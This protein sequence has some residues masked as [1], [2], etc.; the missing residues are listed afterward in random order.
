MQDMDVSVCD[1][2]HMFIETFM[3]F[4]CIDSLSCF[5]SPLWW[6]N[7]VLFDNLFDNLFVLNHIE[8]L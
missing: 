1:I 5:V 6:V 2:M 3:T 7:D 8:Y 4:M